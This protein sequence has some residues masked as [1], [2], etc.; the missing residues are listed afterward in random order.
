MLFDLWTYGNE[1]MP[2]Q[3]RDRRLG[4][5]DIWARAS[6]KGNPYAHPV[7]G[8]KKIVD[9]NSMEVLELDEGHDRGM[10]E[11]D[12]EYVH[13]VRGLAERTLYLIHI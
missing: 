1:V 8:L 13:E 11:V 4:W 6:A 2:E 3:W 9:V 7:S 12:A 5:V 10:P